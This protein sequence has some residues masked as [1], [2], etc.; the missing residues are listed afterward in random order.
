MSENIPNV[1]LY[2]CLRKIDNTKPLQTALHDLG[3]DDVAPAQ[4]QRQLAPG[5]ATGCGLDSKRS[6]AS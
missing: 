5:L 6:A 3:A 4:D 2:R 1:L